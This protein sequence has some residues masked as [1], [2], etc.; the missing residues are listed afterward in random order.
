MDA[1]ADDSAA[2]FAAGGLVARRETRILMAREVLRISVKNIVVDYDFRNDT[3]QDV[4]TEVAFP[5]PPYTQDMEAYSSFSDFKLAIDGRPVTFAI[6]AKATFKGKDVTDILVNDKLDVADFGMS[7]P[8]HPLCENFVALPE[9][10]KKRLV[11]MG[12]VDGIDANECAAH[13]EV[14]LQYHW[15]QTFPAH[16]T[17]H[18]QHEYSPEF[19]FTPDLT[20]KSLQRAL[21]PA[22]ART[23]PK[24]WKSSGAADIAEYCF[25]PEQ[26]RWM[27][28]KIKQNNNPSD[29]YGDLEMKWVDFILTTAN[30][31]QQP[32]E[33]FTLIVEGA[34]VNPIEMH[35]PIVSFCAP[36]KTKVE[37]LDDRHVQ[38]HLTDFV[39]TAELHIGFADVNFMMGEE[40]DIR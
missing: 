33:D 34:F 36:R 25:A 16:S 13:W 19:G 39:P 15:T 21:T 24:L 17:T 12:L 32:I 7:A 23:S 9:S 8:H 38:V 30:T 20:S 2:S 29:V 22:L 5:V 1:W 26:L 28:R 40:G 14:H 4:T 10:E 11:A 31:W 6:E 18:I 3:D 27:I 35:Q 37:K